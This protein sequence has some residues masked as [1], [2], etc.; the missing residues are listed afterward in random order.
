[1]PA[2]PAAA[3]V[4]TASPSATVAPFATAIDPN[5]VRVTA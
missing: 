5:C 1:M 3:T 2:S 4:P